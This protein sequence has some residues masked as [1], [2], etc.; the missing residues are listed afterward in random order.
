MAESSTDAAITLLTG[1]L[2]GGGI[3]FGLWELLKEPC[4][5]GRLQFDCVHLAGQTMLG[6]TGLTATGTV[7]GFVAAGAILLLKDSND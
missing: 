4:A 5:L 6:P 2:G 7:L 3:G 1:P